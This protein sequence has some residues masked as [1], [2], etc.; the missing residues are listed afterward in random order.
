MTS[1]IPPG[2]LC[3]AACQKIIINSGFM[4]PIADLLAE[5]VGESS[6]IYKPAR[7]L[8]VASYA[9]V[10]SW[11]A[12]AARGLVEETEEKAEWHGCDEAT[13][14]MKWVRDDRR[15]HDAEAIVHQLNIWTHRA[16]AR[17]LALVSAGKHGEV[18]TP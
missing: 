18:A 11:H 3:D 9:Y 16:N 12:L 10:E 7:L 4:A 6:P 8:A 14:L 15:E 2:G 17:T 1:H 5:T 13:Q